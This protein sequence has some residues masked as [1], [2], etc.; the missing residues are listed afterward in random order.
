[1]AKGKSR[2]V[3]ISQDEEWRV[4]SDLRTLMD[5]DCIKKDPKRMAKCKAM[6]K[7]KMMESAA[8]AGSDSDD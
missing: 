5:A 6:A 2:A 7:K 1:M 8:V 4:E 3:S